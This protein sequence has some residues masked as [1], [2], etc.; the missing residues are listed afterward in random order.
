ML[1]YPAA[2]DPWCVVDGGHVPV[3]RQAGGVLEDR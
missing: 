3:K 1:G 2:R